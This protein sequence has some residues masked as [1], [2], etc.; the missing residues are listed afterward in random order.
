MI[1]GE[2]GNRKEVLARFIHNSS[3]RKTSPFIA[4]NCSAIPENLFESELFGAC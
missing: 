1:E 2:S 4:I 3:D